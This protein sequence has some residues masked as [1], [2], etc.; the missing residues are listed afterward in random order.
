MNSL[1]IARLAAEAA[2]DKKAQRMV[3]QDLRGLSDLCQ[4]QLVCSGDND[5]Q[6][7]AIADSIEERCKK[8]GVRPVAV[9]GKQTGN[10]ILI[11]FGSVLIHV[12]LEGLRDFYALESLFPKAKFVQLPTLVP[13]TARTVA[14]TE[15]SADDREDLV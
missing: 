13:A 2:S 10:W 4:Y 7:R 3:L 14:A 8:L 5:R 9:E 15:P 1:E 11:D 6:T 12:F